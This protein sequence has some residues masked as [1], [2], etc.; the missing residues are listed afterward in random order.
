VAR[1][2]IYHE[3]L[4]NNIDL[5]QTKEYLNTIREQLIFL[6]NEYVWKTQDT[7]IDTIDICRK[8]LIINTILNNPEKLPLD[9]IFEEIIQ[10][11][12]NGRYEN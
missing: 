9:D 8:I 4:E 7:S 5:N 6:E 3:F 10:T 2:F 1:R 11:E 12:V